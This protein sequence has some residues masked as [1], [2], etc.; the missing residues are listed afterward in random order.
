MSAP[1]F[2]N[3]PAVAK[4]VGAYSHIALVKA[5]SDTFYFSGQVG[6]DAKGDMPEGIEAQADLAFTNILRL[7]EANS[8]TPANIAKLMIFI[9]AGNDANTVRTARKKALGDVRP[10]ST[11]LYVSALAA[12]VLQIEV[13]CVASR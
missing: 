12:P 7:L 1:E 5:G 3:P 9:V 6:M 10:A 13:E 2:S 4:P 11:L 8:M